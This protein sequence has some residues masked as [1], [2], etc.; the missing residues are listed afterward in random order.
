MKS[1][2]TEDTFGRVQ[3]DAVV[4]LLSEKD[5]ELLVVFLGG[6]AKK[7]DIVNESKTEI[8]IFE[9]LVHETLE[10]LGGVT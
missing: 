5:A 4:F 10:R 2:G 7:K 3:Q 1:R 6:T 9:N 8:Q